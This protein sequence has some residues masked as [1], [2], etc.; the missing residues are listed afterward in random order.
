MYYYESRI[1][2]DLVSGKRYR[3][4]DADSNAPSKMRDGT[5]FFRPWKNCNQEGKFWEQGKAKEYV[6][7]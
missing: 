4:V 2:V 7:K 5:A 3:I 1:S 6:E